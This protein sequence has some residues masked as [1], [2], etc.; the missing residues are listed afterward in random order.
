MRSFTL[1]PA[2]LTFAISSAKADELWE[3]PPVLY[4]K[5]RTTDAIARLSSEIARGE[6][7]LPDG[8]ENEVLRFLLQLL[9]VPESSQILVYS[10]TSA[11]NYF[12]SPRTPRALYFNRDAYVGHVL[13]G[14]FEIIIHDPNVGMAFYFIEKDG[15]KFHISRDTSSC[16]NCHATRRTESI[17]GLTIRSVPTDEDGNLLLTLGST[18]TDPTTPIGKRWAGY[19]VTGSSSLPHLGNRIFSTAKGMAEATPSAPLADLNDRIDTSRYLRGTSDIVSL[20]VLEH[21]CLVHNLLARVSM[22]YRHAKWRAS[23]IGG[24]ADDNTVIGSVMPKIRELADAMLFKDEAPMGE[25]GIDG[26]DAFQSDFTADFPKTKEGDSL[27]DF[28]LGNRIFK[29]RCS[30]MIHSQAFTGLPEPVKAAVLREIR[31]R[32]THGN[33]CGW[34]EESERK[35]ILN[36]LGE[37]VPEFR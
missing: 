13:G 35:R 6:T 36:I 22:D 3:L 14:G 30:Y 19:Y 1:F 33:D 37:T 26:A 31:T 17:P 2:I 20:M 27:G 29:N 25:T 5:T 11:Q 4:S 18:R 7:R 16:L 9:E 10:K 28:H 34:I 24:P 21:Q 23:T 15:G 8:P 32:L 12:I